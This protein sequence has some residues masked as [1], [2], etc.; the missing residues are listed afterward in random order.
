MLQI[1]TFLNQIC[2]QKKQ[3]P[4]PNPNINYA[5]HSF[6]F[7]VFFRHTKM[8][9]VPIPHDKPLLLHTPQSILNRN[10]KRVDDKPSRV[11]R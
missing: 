4:Y 7:H 11:L 2:F 6:Q 8:A 9:S 1:T 10:H 3:Y 5:V